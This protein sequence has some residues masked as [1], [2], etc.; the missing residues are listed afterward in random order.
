MSDGIFSLEV[1]VYESGHSYKFNFLISKAVSTQIDERVAYSTQ[2]CIVIPLT[3]C[4]Y[5]SVIKGRVFLTCFTR[6]HFNLVNRYL[7][8]LS[9]ELKV[10]EV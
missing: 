4:A 7:L 1:T 2:A 3:L 6:G 8:H 5:K 10:H 9:T